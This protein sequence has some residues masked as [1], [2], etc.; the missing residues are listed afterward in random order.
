MTIENSVA[1]VTGASMGIGEALARELGAQGAQLVLAARSEEA[2]MRL[3]E[4]IPG[5]I[6]VQTDMRDPGSIANLVAITREQFGRIDLLVNNAG[7]GM[8]S[9]I[10]GIDLEDYRSIMDL[11]VF[12][13]LIAM[14][15]VIPIMREQGGGMILNISSMVS[16]NYFPYLGAYS[17]TKY[18]LNA[19]SLTAR[20]ELAADGISVS[21]FYPKMTATNFGQNAR[22]ETYDSSAGRPGMNVDTAQDVARKIVAQINSEEAEANM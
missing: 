9:P 17:S 15:E 3:A 11:N 12:G 1:I 22:G 19:L 4:E 14:Q 6:A 13:P 18:A 7:Q 10:E 8:R 5:A 16:K 2:L 21:V 20:Q